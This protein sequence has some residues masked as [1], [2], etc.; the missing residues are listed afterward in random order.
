MTMKRRMIIVVPIQGMKRRRRTMT[1]AVAGGI[2]TNMKPT[3]G[4]GLRNVDGNP[5]VAGVLPLWTATR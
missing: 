1:A 5:A 3:T 4:A 2:G